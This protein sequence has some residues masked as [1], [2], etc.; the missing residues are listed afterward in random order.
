[1]SLDEVKE[2]H[3]QQIARFGGTLGIRDEGAL[4]SAVA[5]PEAWFDG[6]FLHRFPFG[7]AAPYAFHIAEAQALLDGNKRTALNAA[8]T[9]LEM[10]G[11][12]IPFSPA[13]EGA[14]IALSS[15]KLDKE[16]LAEL[17]ERCA[18]D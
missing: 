18:A 12:E 16:G 4:A 11:V 10:N 2:I 7:M 3:E 6:G 17:F 14:M 15:K 9:F 8:L 13:L 5:Q 1:M